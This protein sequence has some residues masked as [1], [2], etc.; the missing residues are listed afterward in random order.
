MAFEVFVRV[1][2][3]SRWTDRAERRKGGKNG[4]ARREMS[5][6][7]RRI[8]R[9]PRRNVRNIARHKRTRTDVWPRNVRT[10]SRFA[11]NCRR[12]SEIYVYDVAVNGRDTVRGA[13]G[14]HLPEVRA[15]PRVI[16]SRRRIRVFRSRRRKSLFGKKKL[17]SKSII[18]TREPTVLSWKF[19]RRTNPPS[20][21]CYALNFFFTSPPSA[22]VF[23]QRT[24]SRKKCVFLSV[25]S[26]RLIDKK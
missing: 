15:R 4:S 13:C 22:W 19:G 17:R 16:N 9:A 12:T 2:R 24:G 21:A 8:E 14:V 23:P 5:F 20:N 1:E 6:R 18:E 26:T 11:R 3:R 10:S 7:R 25:R